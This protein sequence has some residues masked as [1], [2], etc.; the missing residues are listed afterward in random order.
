[1]I[2][3]QDKFALM[4]HGFTE[5]RVKLAIKYATHSSIKI[6]ESLI[7]TVIWHC[8][9]TD[10]IDIPKP[11]KE[12]EES[13]KKQKKQDEILVL[14]EIRKYE[15]RKIVNEQWRNF[16]VDFLPI[17]H[18]EYVEISGKKLF[19]SDENFEEQFPNLLLK[20]LGQ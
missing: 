18:V 2:A 10:P 12:K 17:V 1:M 5:E 3:D 4:Q 13:I 19:F 14:K 20:A 16:K 8:R 9:L 15:T 6:K 11:E 7:A